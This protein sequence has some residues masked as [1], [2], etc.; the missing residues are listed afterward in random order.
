MKDY[1]GSEDPDKNP[2]GSSTGKI[3]AFNAVVLNASNTTA[4]KSG[5]FYV[6]T[7][8]ETRYNIAP[9]S[10][11][12]V[13]DPETGEVTEQTVNTPHAWQ[14]RSYAFYRMEI[15][16]Q[17]K[18]FTPTHS[19]VPVYDKT[20]YDNNGDAED[21]MWGLVIS[22]TET[23]NG[24]HGYLTAKQVIDYIE[25]REAI[26]TSPAIES[27]LDTK[28]ETAPA[29][30]K[31][32][33]YIDGTELLSIVGTQT[34][35]VETLKNKLGTNALLFL[36][37]NTTSTLDNVAVKTSSGSFRAGRH[38]VLTDKKPFYSPYNIQVD[39]ANYASYTRDIT[40]ESTGMVKNNTVMLPFTLALEEGVHTN[41]E[42]TPG[43]GTQFTVNTMDAGQN[44]Q[45]VKGQDYGTAYFVKY[46]GK[47]TEANKPYM[48]KVEENGF[49]DQDKKQIFIASQTGSLVLATTT[50]T[51]LEG[52]GSTGKYYVG[53]E[54]VSASSDKEDFVLTNKGSYSGMKFDRADSEKVFYFANDK[55]LDLRTLKKEKRYLYSYPFRAAY[56][57]TSTPKD[58]GAKGLRGF[59]ISY[60]EPQGGTTGIEDATTEADLMVRAGNG[61]I[62][63]TATRA[64]AVA[65]HAI[66]GVSM[67]RIQM[68]AGET[69]VV[70]LPAG[71]YV[72]NNV[73]IVVK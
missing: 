21:N 72:V 47:T 68:N 25:G 37:V 53:E 13:I 56:A 9:G 64:Q 16:V 19:W 36:P 29:S 34:T 57:Y 23:E 3:G 42:G 39:A 38:I 26:G 33:L 71:I 70:N 63:L 65:I 4:Q 43:A 60:D 55:Y 27:K 66:S 7:A 6:F 12:K 24:K 22:T 17:A 11:D 67:N 28:S 10:T 31:Q 49:A 14:H 2:D 1:L 59:F 69:Q 44:L 35:S 40:V 45:K 73:K 18:T 46:T 20:C 41:A 58:N 50:G 5:T 15:E 52:E 48:I 30:M 8:D 51:E 62:T 61:Y 32:I 54:N